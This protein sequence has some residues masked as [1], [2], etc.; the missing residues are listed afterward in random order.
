MKEARTRRDLVAGELAA[1]RNPADTLR[2][3]LAAPAATRSVE[4][5]AERFLASRIDVDANTTKNYR[6]ALRKAGETFGTRD[7]ATLTVDEVAAWVSELAGKHKPGT[8]QLYLIA[9]R[10]LLDYAQ[11]DPNPARDP[12]VKLPKQVREEPNPPTGEQFLAISTR[13]GNGGDSSSS[14]SSRAL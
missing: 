10:L 7:P 4:R 14:R 5:W 2:V 12:R 8:V 6:S 13:W 9:F 11:V 1:G 3:M